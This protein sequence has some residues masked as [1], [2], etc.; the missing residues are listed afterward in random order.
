MPCPQCG[1]PIPVGPGWVN[2]CEACDWNLEGE[3]QQVIATAKT[4]AER[5]AQRRVEQLHKEMIGDP[6]DRRRHSTARIL[7]Y[8]LAALVHLLALMLVAAAAALL[9]VAGVNPF[10]LVLSAV[11]IALAV[12]LRPRLGSIPRKMPT[13][14]RSDAPALFQL[15]DQLASALHA[16]PVQWVAF[17]LDF[18]CSTSMIGTG[19]RRLVVV[20]LPLW[21]ILRSDERLAVLA[22]EVAHDTNADLL[23]GLIVGSAEE[24]LA[25][26]T[27]WLTPA[28]LLARSAKGTNAAFAEDLATLLLRG[29]SLVAYGYFRLLLRYARR[30]SPRAEY[31]AD[32]EAARIASPESSISCLDKLCLARPLMFGFELAAKREDPDI[33]KSLVGISKSYSARDHERLRRIARRSAASADDT[34]P[35]TALR[36]DVL[37]HLPD[38]APAIVTPAEQVEAI[39][40]ELA[41][42]RNH[43]AAVAAARFG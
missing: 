2:W 28:P 40:R 15:L 34:H 4:R 20:G 1:H 36:I 24:I 18:N 5:R 42:V 3:S 43:L 30:A 8:V 23:H 41:N 22:H 32:Q 14:T 10:S 11:L 27:Q 17:N 31:L 26:I 19:R 35:P 9:I 38:S 7:T 37:R 29:F 39:D 16:R 33:W 12:G 6:M 21:V 25:S 13:L